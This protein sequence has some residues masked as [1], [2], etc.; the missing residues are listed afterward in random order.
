VNDLS[1]LE[2]TLTFDRPQMANDFTGYAAYFDIVNEDQSAVEAIVLRDSLKQRAL[3]YSQ[4]K[5]A[6][7]K[8]LYPDIQLNIEQYDHGK[9]TNK[10]IL[11]NGGKILSRRMVYAPPGVISADYP[12]ENQQLH[13]LATFYQP[14][15]KVDY[16]LQYVNGKREGCFKSLHAS[17]KT[18]TQACYQSDKLVG[19]FLSYHANGTIAVKASYDMQGSLTGDYVEYYESGKPKK[20]AHYIG[21]LAEGD[22]AEWYESGKDRTKTRY[23]HGKILDVGHTYFENGDIEELFISGSASQPGTHTRYYQDGSLQSKVSVIEGVYQGRYEQFHPNK[24]TAMVAN[25]DK[26]QLDGKVSQWDEFG[27]IASIAEFRAGL[28]QSATTYYLHGGMYAKSY[29][30]ANGALNKMETFDIYGALDFSIP[31]QNGKIHGQVTRYYRNGQ[32]ALV[33]NF[34]QGTP[35]YPIKGLGIDG[36]D[37]YIVNYNNNGDLIGAAIYNTAGNIREYLVVDNGIVKQGVNYESGTPRSFSMT[38]PDGSEH[39]EYYDESTKTVVIKQDFTVQQSLKGMYYFTGPV[40]TGCILPDNQSQYECGSLIQGSSQPALLENNSTLNML[41]RVMTENGFFKPNIS[42][43]V[44]PNASES[45]FQEN[46]AQLV[47]EVVSSDTT[48]KRCYD[49]GF[50]EYCQ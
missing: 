8:P 27:R 2:Q 46:N 48:G 40:T 34:N 26:G 42:V 13:G 11:V 12:Y 32:P 44:N 37:A 23:T 14:N 45:I 16:T 36:K 19:D 10:V 5:C 1:Q 15:G 30:D 43:K 33:A 35:V 3:S 50:M 29:F 41:D 31:Y 24:K 39:R 20:S 47:Q 38:N 49:L 28:P 17:G 9:L 22:Y 21:G 7:N 6:P 25:Y 4:Q 18:K